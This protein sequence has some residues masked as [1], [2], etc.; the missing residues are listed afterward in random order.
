MTAHGGR[1]TDPADSVLV[2][3]DVQPAFVDKLGEGTA[4]RVLSRIAWLTR[5][6]VELQIPLAVTE[7]LSE[8]NGSTVEAVARW[9][10]PDVRP[11]EKP[12]FGLAACPPIMADLERHGR[13]T[14][15][16]VGFETDVC[17]A[18][19]ALGLLDASWK[20]VV[21]SD[22]VACPGD[23]HEQGLTRMR[24]AGASL[25]GMKGVAYEWIRTLERADRVPRVLWRSAPPGITL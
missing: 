9:L 12:I 7:E 18:Q 20:V 22:A 15:V 10:P 14:A 5:L 2:V 25:A 11:H 23:A 6:A 1:L 24:D 21:V 8:E 19:S 13:G 4:D 17:V 3:I 16:L